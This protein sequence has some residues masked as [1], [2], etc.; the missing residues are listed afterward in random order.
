MYF[1][2][3]QYLNQP[4]LDKEHP[5]ILDPVQYWHQY[6][7]DRLNGCLENGFL[8]Q[9]WAVNYQEFVDY[10]QDFCDRNILEEDPIWLIERCWQQKNYHY[11]EQHP[12][13]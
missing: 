6:K 4:L 12:E 11:L 5:L 3:W 10:H 13:K 8:E 1:P 2:I 9:C 7:I